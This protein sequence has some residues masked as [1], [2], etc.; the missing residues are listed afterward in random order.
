LEAKV[1]KGRKWWKKKRGG[2]DK[3]GNENIGMCFDK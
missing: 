1:K 3:N 2:N